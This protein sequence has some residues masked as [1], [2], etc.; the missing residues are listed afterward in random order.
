[1][2]KHNQ[3]DAKLAYW[4]EKYLLFQETRTM[5]SLVWDLGSSQIRGAAASQD[6]IGWVDFLHGKV[7][8]AIAKIQ[9]IHCTL[10]SCR[11]T[12]DDWMKHFIEKLLK[13]LHSQWL[14]WNFTLLD[15]TRGYLHLQRRK[16]VLKEVDCLMDM[17]LEGKTSHR[18][19]STYWKWTSHPCIMPH[20][21]GSP[22]G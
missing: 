8:V 22:I 14:Y 18:A 16:E 3:T 11:M 5:S 19:A 12:G 7:S 4:I 17:N 20:L 2:H 9:E 1:M 6:M 15:K 13:V 10:S 21:S